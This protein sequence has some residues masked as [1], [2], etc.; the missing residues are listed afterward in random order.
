MLSSPVLLAMSPDQPVPI[1]SQSAARK[2]RRLFHS[3][4][5]ARALGYSSHFGTHLASHL[6]LFPVVD[7][8][9]LQ[10]PAACPPRNSMILNT[11]HFDGGCTPL[12]DVQTVRLAV[13]HSA[14]RL[15][16]GDVSHPY[17]FFACNT[18]EP[19]R[20]CCKQ[21]AYSSSKPF[22]C[23]TYKNHKGWGSWLTRTASGPAVQVR[24]SVAARAASNNFFAFSR[25]SPLLK[26]AL[27]AT[28]NSAPAR[29]ISPTVSS[30]TPPSISIRKDS[31]SDSRTST[32]VLTLCSAPGINFCA[33]NPGFTD[34]IRTWCT[35]SK[36]SST[37][38]T[39][40]A[41]FSTTPDLHPCESIS[42][43]V[44]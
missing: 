43:S 42:C 29:T 7:P 31:P 28:S 44:R 33:P 24:V 4:S 10:Q 21:K 1:L 23:N 34:M 16:L 35:M 41:G 36:T 15:R 20:K 5:S 22:R 3:S 27:P 19:P 30:D 18:Y 8:V 9:S 32:S 25:M 11:F 13:A 17:K 26:T 2:P 37:I 40:V 6:P 14:S 38:C 39:G 12:L